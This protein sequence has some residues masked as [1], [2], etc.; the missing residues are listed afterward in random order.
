MT[1]HDMTRRGGVGSPAA[2]PPQFRPSSTLAAK[3]MEAC[4]ATTNKSTQ[5]MRS[6][7]ASQQPFSE[8]FWTSFTHAAGVSR[9]GPRPM[10]RMG[11]SR[12]RLGRPCRPHPAGPHRP[13]PVFPAPIS[14]GRPGP[15][16]G[17]RV[18]RLARR[19]PGRRFPVRRAARMAAMASGAGTPSSAS[20]RAAIVPVPP[21][22]PRRCSRTRRPAP[23]W[24]RG[25]APDRAKAPRTA[26]E[27]L[28]RDIPVDD[29]RV[30]SRHAERLDHR[31]GAH[32]PI[33]GRLV[34]FHKRHDCDGASR[35]DAGEVERQ[36][37]V[38]RAV[39]GVGLRFAGAE[40]HAG[41]LVPG[42]STVSIRGR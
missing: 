19:R 32:D 1:G 29:R 20:K 23:R 5:F 22:P 21:G 26:R 25:P 8:P 37:A 33:A 4:D 13:A 38:P 12:P 7:H 42:A 28:A 15:R 6:L 36:V 11:R 9:G 3:A 41:R 2:G 34:R 39:G 35:S 27:R 30:A 40:R 31:A 24:S 10:R 14:C 16:R 17:R 18:G